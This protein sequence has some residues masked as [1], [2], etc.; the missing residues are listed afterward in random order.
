MAFDA[1]ERLYVGGQAFE[2]A[3]VLPATGHELLVTDTEY[4]HVYT[5]TNEARVGEELAR[6]PLPIAD[7]HLLRAV[8][9]NDG[10]SVFAVSST[11]SDRATMLRILLQPSID[12]C[13]MPMPSAF[14]LDVGFL[15]DDGRID[16]SAVM[17]C[18]YCTTSYQVFYG[19]R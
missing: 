11:L 7:V 3:D 4:L 13:R 2:I 18:S 12:L 6:V 8:K 5:Q 1:T 15:D 16:L 9:T 17:T 14:V 10:L 19:T